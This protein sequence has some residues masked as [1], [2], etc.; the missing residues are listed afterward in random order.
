MKNKYDDEYKHELYKHGE[1]I[2]ELGGYFIIDGKE[3]II[4]SQER[5]AY[6]KLYTHTDP[7]YILITE[8]KSAKT[9]SFTPAKNTYIKLRKLIRKKDKTTDLN[10]EDVDIVSLSKDTIDNE[11]KSENDGEINVDNKE[12][13]SHNFS[14]DEVSIVVS[15]PGLT[16]DI[17][18]FIIFMHLLL[19]PCR[20]SK[21][22]P[23]LTG[24]SPSTTSRAASIT[25][26]PGRWTALPMPTAQRWR[27]TP[28]PHKSHH[29]PCPERRRRP[30]PQ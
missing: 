23:P 5:L 14:S 10:P 2:N 27:E 18:L 11:N 16:E 29:R 13:Q 12:V 9:D 26:A 3:K 21:R 7:K 17:P 4:I 8:V 15:F 19:Q 30:R 20:G 22:S 28:P 24:R 1:C 25:L 6:N